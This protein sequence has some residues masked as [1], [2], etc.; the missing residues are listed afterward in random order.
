MKENTFLLAETFYPI[1]S[2]NTKIIETLE[3][4][5]GKGCVNVVAWNRENR[6]IKDSHGKYYIYTKYS[7]AGKLLQ[8]LFHLLGYG[9]FIWK[10]NKM[11]SCRFLI[12]S[13]WEILLLFSLFKGKNQILIYENLDIPTSNNSCVL[14]ILQRLEKWS[15]R[16]VEAIIFAS[17]F[18]VPLYADHKGTKI[19]L[20]NKP[21]LNPNVKVRVLEREE[22]DKLQIAYIG[23]VRYLPIM[24]NLVDSVGGLNDIKLLIHGD[25][26]CLN[27][28]SEYANEYK[29]IIFT[30]RYEINQLES[31]YNSCDVVWAVYPNDDYNVKYAISNKFHE[32]LMYQVP[33]IYASNTCLGEYVVNH[34]LGWVVNPY[35]IL[36]IREKIN[37]IKLNRENYNNIVCR[38]FEDFKK[39]KSWNNDFDK[40]KDFIEISI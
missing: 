2:R 29:N 40:L 28:L 32:S 9:C 30:G 39:E 1:N 20:E 18:F 38:L 19:V 12:A 26:P 15:L 35:N 36:E 5:Y 10:I 8:K 27:E 23:C 3:S 4:L 7:P 17:R 24:K 14:H 31:L 16:K 11:L 33:C 25:G 13:H 22:F 37:E 21:L 6:M 34:N